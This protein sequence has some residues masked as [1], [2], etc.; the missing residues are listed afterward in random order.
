MFE[1]SPRILFYALNG[2]GLGHVNRTVLIARDL[3]HLLQKLYNSHSIFFVTEAEDTFLIKDAHF[4]CYNLPLHESSTALQ[5]TIKGKTVRSSFNKP[6]VESIIRQFKPHIMVFDFYFERDLLEAAKSNG[7]QLVLILRKQPDDK[8]EKRLDPSG[9]I[10][11]FDMIIIPKDTEKNI[12]PDIIPGELLSKIVF[13]NPIVRRIT[14]STDNNNNDRHDQLL[15]RYSL[16]NSKI[17]VT[18]SAGAGG[19]PGTDKYYN[20]VIRAFESISENRSDFQGLIFTGPSYKGHLHSTCEQI[21]IY[22][23]EP[24]L[25]NVLSASTV[26]I[27]QAGYNTINEIIFSGIP[28]IVVPGKR[29]SDDQFKRAA[30]L[31]EKNCIVMLEEISSAIL[32]SAILKLIQNESMRNELS[33][34]I[35]RYRKTNNLENTGN[36]KAASNILQLGYN[37]TLQPIEVTR[38]YTLPTVAWPANTPPDKA[39]GVWQNVAIELKKKNLRNVVIILNIN[40]DNLASIMDITSFLMWCNCKYLCLEVPDSLTN[41]ERV[42]HYVQWLS[43]Q[44]LPLHIYFKEFHKP[45]IPH[46]GGLLND[47]IPSAQVSRLQNVN[48]RIVRGC[49]A[50][51]YFCNHWRDPKAKEQ[52]FELSKIIHIYNQLASLGVKSVV[53]NGGEP[54]IHRY[55]S[56]IVRYGKFVGMRITA[57]TNAT[58]LDNVSYTKEVVES[59]L[60]GVLISLH[61]SESKIHDRIKAKPGWWQRTINGITAL[62]ECSDKID[63]RINVV[64]IKD[65][66]LKA[67]EI[68]KLVAKIGV[69]SIQ[70]S[71]V[72]DLREVSNLKSRLDESQQQ[73]FYFKIYPEVI[74]FCL[75]NNIPTKISPLPNQLLG[76]GISKLGLDYEYSMEAIN[77]LNHPS[78]ELRTEVQHYAT[79]MYGGAFYSS[80]GCFVPSTT[81]YIMANGDVYPCVRS[82]GFEDSN[83]IIGNVYSKNLNEILISDKYVDFVSNAGINDACKTCKNLHGFNLRKSNMN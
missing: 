26:S 17:T 82:I 69:N 14:T 21:K 2:V 33:T 53:L 60:D 15:R 46:V 24:H 36:K 38:E 9:P 51:C 30:S 55:F 29:K 71:Q 80:H 48:W 42:E 32:E 79:G 23:Y 64:L 67:L 18:A 22:P 61:S 73:E 27:T 28:A 25:L 6:I 77:I 63:I 72:D 19:Y 8:M 75:D 41:S 66:Y 16:N 31:A 37:T 44:K 34:N 5:H 56:F 76:N 47:N 83:D 58:L 54:L 52:V 49:N 59:G 39:N 12:S 13:T 74:Q 50:K 3:R 45:I 10:N 4:P 35:L 11:L 57:N 81:T 20:A 7:S 65:N 68:A 78:S 1:N 40:R 70:F 43:S 62:R